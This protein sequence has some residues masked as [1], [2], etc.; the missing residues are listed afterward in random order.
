MLKFTHHITTADF[1]LRKSS[2]MIRYHYITLHMINTTIIM[3][4]VLLLLLCL[5]FNMQLLPTFCLHPSVTYLPFSLTIP[6][7][8]HIQHHSLILMMGKV[9][10]IRILYHSTDI[11]SGS[12]QFFIMLATTV[13][14]NTG[15]TN[16]HNNF[17]ESL[18]AIPPYN[19]IHS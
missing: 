10:R 8:H 13:P 16:F 9:G 6:A 2:V 4:K 1:M 17:T 19:Y 7:E 18:T 15:T 12:L 3:Y 5:L 14:C 11:L